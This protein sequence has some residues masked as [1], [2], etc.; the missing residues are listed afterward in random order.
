[1]PVPSGIA[2]PLYL[3]GAP[4]SSDDWIALLERT[5]GVAPDLIGFGRSGKGGHLEYTLDGLATFIERLV[6]ELGL[7]RIAVVGHQWGAAAALV[8]AQREPELIERLA[9]CDAVPL[10]AGFAWPRLARVIRRPA[11]GELLMGS[12]SRRLLARALRRGCARPETFSDDRLATIWEQF[13]QGTQRAIVRLHRSASEHDLAAAGQRLGDIDAPSLV[14]WG[15]LDPWLSADWGDRYGERLANA[16]V[17]RVTDAGHWP[18]L[19]SDLAADRVADFVG[20]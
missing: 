4:T 12:T 17:V 8:L 1:V 2:T 7:E 20:G 16:E 6:L 10:I 11:F 13:D 9:L 3:H 5:G 14:L 19:E 18:W 15:E